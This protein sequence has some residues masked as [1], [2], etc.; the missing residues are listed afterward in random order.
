MLQIIHFVSIEFDC[1]DRGRSAFMLHLIFQFEKAAHYS[2]LFLV[3]AKW[4]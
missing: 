3:S 4:A 1:V 2:F